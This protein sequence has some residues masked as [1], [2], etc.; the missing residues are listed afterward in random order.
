MPTPNAIPVDKLVR[1]IG[2]PG[3]PVLLDVRTEEDFAA[4]PCLI[5]SAVRRPWAEVASWAG[6]LAG[7]SAIVICQRG[8]KLS[9]GVAAWLRQEGVP[10]ESL[11]GGT[12]A[13]R[14]AE[15]PTVPDA[16]L[17]TRD[18]RGRTVWVT[19]ARPK[20]DRIACPWLI[21]RFVDPSAVFLFV[22]SP[23]VEAVAA[24]FGG[25]AF[26]IDDPEV[27]WSHRGE[28]CTFDVLVEELNLGTAPLRQ[29]AAIV[30]GA[31]TARLDLA[32]EAAGLLAASLGLSRM[33]ADDLEQLNAGMLLYDAF[34]RW[35]R[36]A[37]DET[38]NWPTN[39]PKPG[40]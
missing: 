10:A 18:A 21:R 12:E 14:A 24:R 22:P 11:E 27:V 1:L 39:K 23:E 7:R 31:D 25:A 30:R 29:L 20:I 35:C 13:W 26:D 19:R 40:V 34:Y 6:A 36:D 32:P 3:C 37:T 17:P 38:H 9:H 5:P 16:K 33:Y 2:T 28:L 15:L 8:Q 4:D